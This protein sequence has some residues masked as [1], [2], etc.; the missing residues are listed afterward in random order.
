MKHLFLLHADNVNLDGNNIMKNTKA[1]PHASKEIGLEVHIEKT[2]YMSTSH[3]QN[4]G[5]D[6][7]IK[8]A[9]GSFE[10]GAMFKYFRTMLRDQN[11]IHDEIKI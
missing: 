3:H 5:Q 2:M 4:T 6:H 7:N 11:L 8:I 9:R 10:Y 1:L